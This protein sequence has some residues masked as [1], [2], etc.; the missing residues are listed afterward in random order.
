MKNAHALFQ[1]L[2]FIIFIL[3]CSKSD[4]NFENDDIVCKISSYD[5]V[6]VLN[7][8]AST[9]TLKF[10]YHYDE[11]G[12]LII[13]GLTSSTYDSVA[14][15]N[16]K[17]DKIL[18]ISEGLIAYFYEF[19]YVNDDVIVVQQSVTHDNYI[20]IGI[21]SLFYENDQ[22]IEVKKYIDRIYNDTT[23]VFEPKI[24]RR[25]I[26]EYDSDGNLFTAKT[27]TY[28]LSPPMTKL[29]LA[30]KHMVN[31]HPLR[32]HIIVLYFVTKEGN[33]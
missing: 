25:E 13:R 29:M 28:S 1:F 12:K 2:L 22:L 27:Y 23:I 20:E 11:F 31:I 26:F 3:S 33:H 21:D 5:V 19:D 24:F 7:G 10:F 16:N 17:V 14:Y 15:L 18:R 4:D 6:I 8:Q 9:D 30:L 32:I